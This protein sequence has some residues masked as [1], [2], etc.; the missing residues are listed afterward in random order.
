VI[1]N[2]AAKYLWEVQQA[3]ERIMRL[4]ADRTYDDYLSDEMLSAAVERQF[5]IIGEPLVSLRR[6]ASET[7]ALIPDV[8][9]MIGFRNALVHDYGDVDSKE[10]WGNIQEHLPGLQRT[11][12]NL[13]RN[14][15][16]PRSGSP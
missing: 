12:A 6:I 2:A 4:T 11:V 13:L 8:A 10:V 7:A 9:Q 5:Q 3:A 14:V 16:S 1:T 15:A